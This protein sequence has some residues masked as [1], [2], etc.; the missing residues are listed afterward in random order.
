[1]IVE[2]MFIYKNYATTAAMIP[3]TRIRIPMAIPT[4]PSLEHVQNGSL[5]CFTIR[6]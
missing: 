4:A 3:S 6:M 1:M 5:A 2:N